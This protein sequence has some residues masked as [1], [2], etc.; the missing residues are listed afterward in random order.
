MTR[1]KHWLWLMPS[2]RYRENE[3]A[4]AIVLIACSATVVTTQRRSGKVCVADTSFLF[5]R[6][7]TPKMAAG[8]AD[9]DG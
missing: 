2:P 9:G 1:S 5:L 4:H 6:S 3:D 7:A 8:W